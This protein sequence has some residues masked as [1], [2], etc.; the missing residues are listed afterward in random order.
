MMNKNYN[1]RFLVL[2]GILILFAFAITINFFIIMIIKDPKSFSYSEM[3][4]RRGDIYDSNGLALALHK[5]LFRVEVIPNYINKKDIIYE[6][7]LEMGLLE[8]QELHNRIYV[9]SNRTYTINRKI[10][11]DDYMEIKYF[12]EENNI[13]GIYLSEYFGRIYPQDEIASHVIGYVNYRNDGMTGIEKTFDY[14]LKPKDEYIGNSVFTTIDLTSQYFAEAIIDKAVK[15]HQPNNIIILA[16]EAKTGRILAWAAN[17]SY[18]PNNLNLSTDIDRK[19][20]PSS[21]VYEPG[22]V[23][24]VFS[25]SAALELGAITPTDTFVSKGHFII[26][27]TKNERIGDLA[28]SRNMSLED[29]IRESSNVGTALAVQDVS[30]QNLYNKLT[31]FGFGQ[32]TG[33]ELGFEESGILRSPNRWS[34]RSQFSIAMGQE[35]FTTAI[36]IVSAATVF[37]NQGIRLKP[38]IVDRIETP[39]GKIVQEFHPQ[40]VKT[41]IS[42]NIAKIMLDMMNSAAETGTAWRS[43]VAGIN[44]SSKT[45]TSQIFD[46]KNK[47]YSDTEFF[48][49]CL[50]LLPT[51]DPEII[52]YVGITNPKGDEYYGGRIAAP[53]IH[54]LAEQMILNRGI[55]RSSDTV[56]SHSGNIT[57]RETNISSLGETMPN[58]LGLS[59]REIIGL[60]ELENV[61]IKFIG[62]GWVKSQ[63][64]A[65]GSII[66]EETE[67]ELR[68]E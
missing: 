62:E 45:G 61:K 2:A 63:Y 11:F 47:K 4:S 44:L 58:F 10:E 1:K 31:D 54:E 51:E 6:K 27:G 41:V 28:T 67:I 68:F 13:K 29:V 8:A 40:E 33:I 25:L 18:D 21:F 12:T 46:I 22:S 16:M 59:K 60:Y 37:A 66:D 39:D 14:Y 23:F 20:Y 17:P 19:N 42:P 38:M 24:K 65:A 9:N 53:I 35:I 5:Q 48:A 32:S 55:K 34:N 36:Q 52:L 7:F 49:S 64:P 56:I 43:R 57:Y 3:E 26:P 15:D 50:T 30:R